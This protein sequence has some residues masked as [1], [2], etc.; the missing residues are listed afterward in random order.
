MEA[1]RLDRTVAC[2]LFICVPT[3]C[4][5]WAWAGI[6]S[7]GSLCEGPP[8]LTSDRAWRLASGRLA[9]TTVVCTP[10]QVCERVSMFAFL[11]LTLLSGSEIGLVRY[12]P[13]LCPLLHSA[14]ATKHPFLL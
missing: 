10:V 3:G 13:H 8:T 1:G 14:E 5:A 11:M 7:V 4:P 12:P 2:F 9:L 6:F